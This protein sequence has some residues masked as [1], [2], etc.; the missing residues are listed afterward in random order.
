MPDDLRS[1]WLR[2]VADSRREL[3]RSRKDQ[4][5][6]DPDLDLDSLFAS[7]WP[8][9]REAAIEGLAREEAGDDE[10]LYRDVR[11]RLDRDLP[12]EYPYARR[13]ADSDE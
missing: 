9:A 13:D 12:R 7:H 3:E 2:A 11:R 1:L 6:I 5:G 4:P 8:K 10:S